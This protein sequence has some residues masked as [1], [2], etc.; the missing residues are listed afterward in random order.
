M[1]KLIDVILLHLFFRP[2]KPETKEPNKGKIK[3]ERYIMFL[4]KYFLLI[5][6]KLQEYLNLLLILLPAIEIIKIL[7]V[8]PIPSSK[9]KLE[10]NTN[11]VTANNINSM[12]II[13]RI[14]FF[15]FKNKT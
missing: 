12:A 14:I 10:I 11:K 8:C 7:N 1:Y 15:L 9:L 4:M 2:I 5:Y 3:I 13:I 6:N